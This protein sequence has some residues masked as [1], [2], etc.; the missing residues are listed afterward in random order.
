MVLTKERAVTLNDF[1]SVDTERAGKLAALTPSEAVAQIN[2]HG[3]DFTVAELMEYGEAVN[4]LNTHGELELDALED[5]AGGSITIVCAVV[6]A[7]A[8]TASAISSIINSR[9]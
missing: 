7:A 9:W 1:L 5:V 3:H 4:V 8:G 6:G 2:A